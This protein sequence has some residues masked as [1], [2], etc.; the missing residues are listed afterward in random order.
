MLFQ[1]G[2][3]E[4]NKWLEDIFFPALNSKGKRCLW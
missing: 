4:E 2:S 3:E 1:P